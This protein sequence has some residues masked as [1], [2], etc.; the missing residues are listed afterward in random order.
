M[1][2]VQIIFL[3]AMFFLF[4]ENALCSQ[5]TGTVA[6]GTSSVNLTTQGTLDWAVWG[7]GSSTS[8][9]PAVRQSGGSFISNLT[10]VNPNGQPLRG[11]G[12]FSFG[13]SF[14]WTNGN[15][16][17][18]GTNVFAGL[19]S[20]TE[21]GPG[22][23]VN[24]GFSFTVPADTSIRR[25][26]VYIHAHHGTCQ[27]TATLSDGSASPYV[28]SFVGGEITGGYYTID[29]AAA[30]V[31]QLTVLW[32]ETASSGTY[33]HPAIYAVTLSYSP[34]AIDLLSFAASDAGDFVDITWETAAEIENA[35]FH[36]W[37]CQDNP[38]DPDLYTKITGFMIPAQGGATWGAKYRYEDFSIQPGATYFYKLEAIDDGGKSSFYGPV[39]VTLK[40]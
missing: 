11:I 33:D 23:G 1:K 18:T 21:A 9:I 19:Q 2:P 3:L 30:S 20:W 32:Q 40:P 29:Y 13:S 38:Q 8:L 26:V 24:Q 31:S 36:L 16:T 10:Y 12:Q 7:T 39:Q 22:L 27:L 17:P 37:R 5:L 6:A 35:G 14:S 25:L 4:A 28:H 15:T 34:T